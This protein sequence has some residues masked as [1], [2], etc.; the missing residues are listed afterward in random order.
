MKYMKRRHYLLIIIILFALAM[1]GFIKALNESLSQQKSREQVLNTAQPEIPAPIKTQAPG[2]EA[3]VVLDN[4]VEGQRI[5]TP[6]SITGK[7]K[8]YYFEGSFPVQLTTN[9]GTV[10]A[11]SIAQARGD[12]MTAEYVPFA[13][14]INF[15]VPQGTT[16]GYLVFIKDNPTGEARFDK[17]MAIKVQW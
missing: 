8:G 12:W 14:T 13:T 2:I 10:I 6:L 1:W 4:L 11:T 7:A 16:G 9:D 17:S 3:D 5:A 15:V